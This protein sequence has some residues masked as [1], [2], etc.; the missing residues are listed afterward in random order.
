MFTQS[1]NQSAIVECIQ[2]LLLK[3]TIV[4]R[5]Y[6]SK[7]YAK[8]SVGQHEPLTKRRYDQVP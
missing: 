4:N 8:S 6:N 2:Y 5:D 3:L 1:H 7:T